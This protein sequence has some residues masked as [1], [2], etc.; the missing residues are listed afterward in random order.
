MFS[1]L[2]RSLC[3]FNKIIT[4]YLSF[5]TVKQSICL[6]AT[7]NLIF[8]FKGK[9][10]QFFFC[11]LVQKINLKSSHCIIPQIFLKAKR[12][13]ALSFAAGSSFQQ[14]TS[15]PLYRTELLSSVQSCIRENSRRGE[16]NS[17]WHSSLDPLS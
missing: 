8:F 9:G 12:I 4:S 17:S 13:L 14:L 15:G 6:L 7:I 11:G 16:G 3:I 5:S 2:L 10:Y 1:Q